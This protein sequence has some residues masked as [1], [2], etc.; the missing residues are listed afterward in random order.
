MEFEID[1]FLGFSKLTNH[2]RSLQNLLKSLPMFSPQKSIPK[3]KTALTL[4]ELPC[5][6]G[7]MARMGSKSWI[8]GREWKRSSLETPTEVKWQEERAAMD[9]NTQKQRWWWSSALRS[10]FAVLNF[11]VAAYIWWKWRK[12]FKKEEKKKSSSIGMCRRRKKWGWGSMEFSGNDKHVPVKWRIDLAKRRSSMSR[13]VLGQEQN[14]K[15]QAMQLC[16]SH[17]QTQNPIAVQ[18]RGPE[19]GSKW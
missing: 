8:E 16:L 10:W 17:P 18:P 5:R 13:V 12:K 6:Q 11:E 1:T 4:G 7:F 3:L 14:L 19:L 15:G 9:E 2:S